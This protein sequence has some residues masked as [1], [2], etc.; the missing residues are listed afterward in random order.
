MRVWVLEVCCWFGHNPNVDF[1]LDHSPDPCG[2][3]R[4][5]LNIKTRLSSSRP[6]MMGEADDKENSRDISPTAPT[7]SPNRMAT[8]QED[9]GQPIKK[10]QMHQQ[11]DQS[12]PPPP[13]KP[14]RSSS[15]SPHRQSK[16]RSKKSRSKPVPE[17]L[18]KWVSNVQGQTEAVY[19]AK[20][21][22]I[23]RLGSVDEGC[24]GVFLH[25][26][27]HICACMLEIG[28]TC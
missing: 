18:K 15:V 19:K 6:L 24:I 9:T 21:Q 11:L 12:D 5:L 25:V 2:S 3:K 27:G 1:N 23:K 20:T 4:R 7:Q 16:K 14:R 13:P 8:I 17:N 10:T 22:G 26:F 28:G